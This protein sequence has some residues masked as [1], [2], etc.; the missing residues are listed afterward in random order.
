[1]KQ[2]ISHWL[3]VAVVLQFGVLAGSAQTGI[4]LYTGF[5]MTIN[6]NPGTYDFTAYGAQGSGSFSGGGIGGLGAKMSGEFFL[7]APTTLTVL[8]GGG[9]VVGYS[10]YFG[11]AGGGG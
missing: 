10:S 2:T 4:Y 5:E 6:L 8:V 7:S 3:P 9:G 1:M 11:G